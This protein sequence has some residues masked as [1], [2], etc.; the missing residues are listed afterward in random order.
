MLKNGAEVLDADDD[1]KLVLDLDMIKLVHLDRNVSVEGLFED[2]LYLLAI[3]RLDLSGGVTTFVADST[4]L[5]HLLG[6]TRKVH[7]SG[8]V[9]GVYIEKLYPWAE[10]VHE[11]T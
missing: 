5:L 3:P 7:D 9:V 8:F 11:L 4:T 6:K 10:V 2:S 1:V